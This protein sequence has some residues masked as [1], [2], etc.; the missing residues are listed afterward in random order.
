MR[1]VL[2]KQQTSVNRRECRDLLDRVDGVTHIGKG[3]HAM[4]A[5]GRPHDAAALRT[6]HDAVAELRAAEEELDDA[7][8]A[9]GLRRRRSRWPVIAMIVG[10]VAAVVCAGWSLLGWYD[11]AGAPTDDDFRD[12]AIARVSLLLSP[13]HRDP[14]QAA[15]ILA[16]ATDPFYDEF[17]QSADSY[18]A[19]ISSRGTRA[20]G[21]ITGTG[22][23]GRTEDSATVLVAARVRFESA[24]GTD[25]AGGSAAGTADD[26]QFRLRVL[27][28]DD[29]GTLKLSAVQY[30]P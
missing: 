14:D 9:A 7:E 1:N 26:Q 8:I 10:L 15:R 4:K 5:A 12:A 27:I 17:A 2:A 3:V 18:A 25:A 22:V 19:F 13:D 21:A 30:L 16:G 28:V 24:G 6:A 11:A 23:S 20:T 29:D